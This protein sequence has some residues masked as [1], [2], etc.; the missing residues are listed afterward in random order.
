MFL[1][2]YLPFATAFA[3]ARSHALQDKGMCLQQD[4]D[5]LR[6]DMERIDQVKIDLG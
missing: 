3:T 5:C 2:R 4:F 1:P 6:T